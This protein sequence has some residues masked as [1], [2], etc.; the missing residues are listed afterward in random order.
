MDEVKPTPIRLKRKYLVGG[1]SRYHAGYGGNNN[2]AKQHRK[3]TEAEI[4]RHLAQPVKVMVIKN[5]GPARM[6]IV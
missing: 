4:A 5:N 3:L 2:P 6:S 1:K